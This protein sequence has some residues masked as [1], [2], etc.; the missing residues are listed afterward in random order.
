MVEKIIYDIAVMLTD[1]LIPLRETFMIFDTSGSG[2]VYRADFISNILDNYLRLSQTLTLN[3]KQLLTQRYA[4]T[5]SVIQMN[6]NLFIDDLLR[7]QRENPSIIR[8]F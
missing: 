6:Y 3:K 5:D 7:K 8:I 1:S 4:P 2:F